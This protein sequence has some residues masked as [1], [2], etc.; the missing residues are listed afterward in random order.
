MY[1]NKDKYITVVTTLIWLEI[2]I[3]LAFNMI[4][5]FVT[6]IT[7]NYMINILAIIFIINS[8]MEFYGIHKKSYWFI[9]FSCIFK[10]SA[11]GKKRALKKYDQFAPVMYNFMKIYNTKNFKCNLNKMSSQM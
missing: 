6:K 8:F 9:L 2:I 1:H 11:I 7:N 3:C 5:S 4:E 10:L